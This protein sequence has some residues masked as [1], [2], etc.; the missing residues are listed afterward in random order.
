[1]DTGVFL[2]DRTIKVLFWN[3]FMVMHTGQPAESVEGRNLFELFPD[4]PRRW[5]ERKVEG[6]FVLKNQAF[7][8]WE[9]R[10]YLFK[11]AHNRPVTGGVESMYQD[12]SL[13]PVLDIAG[14]AIAVC[15]S[16]RDVTDAAIYATRM[17]ETMETLEQEKNEQRILIK[18]L[19]EAQSQLLQSE[20]MAAIGQLAAGV[21]HEINNPIGFIKSNMTSLQKYTASLVQLLE[22]YIKIEDQLDQN[23]SEMQTIANTKDQIDFEYLVEDIG[24]LMTESM[25]GVNRV[26]KI[27]KDL[28]DFSHVDQGDW[29]Y[30]D[31]H[32]CID[33]TLNVAWN[34]LK[35]KAE[36]KKQ[37]GE[38]PQV[39]C[40]GS[41]LNQVFLNLLVNAAHAIENRGIITITTAQKGE[42]VLIT[43]ADTGSGMNQEQLRRVFEPFFTTKP[44]GK[45]TGLGMSLSYGIIDKHEGKIEVESQEGEGTTF[46]IWLPIEGPATRDAL[47]A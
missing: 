13:M 19:E 45:G 17:K 26:S 44:V 29:K 10:P 14:K 43:V 21:A 4:F 12:V 42:K 41:Q 6:V 37:Y 1:M 3:R 40:M 22:A 25:D 30:E 28:K 27:V 5:F 2:V 38:V 47:P 18:K 7:S 32:R 20:K 15:V 23:S 8:S 11:F 33:S 35:Y 46:N 31:L 24:D 36:I 34:E 16:I 39:F 9:Q